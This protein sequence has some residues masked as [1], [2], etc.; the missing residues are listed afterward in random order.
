MSITEIISGS[1]TATFEA[2]VVEEY[3]STSSPTGTPVDILDGDVKLDGTAKIRGSLNITVNGDFPRRG[4]SLLA[5]YG[6]EIFIRRGVDIGSEIL[7]FPLGYFRITNVDQTG[8]SDSPIRIFGTDR[9]STILDSR[10]LQPRQFSAGTT[11]EDIFDNV[12]KEIYPDAVISFD[13]DSD[14]AVIGRNLV[15][16]EQRY[17][18]LNNIATALGKVM[19]FDGSGVLQIKSPPNSDTPVWEVNAGRHGVLINTSRRLSREGVYNAV[20]ARGEGGDDTVPVVGVAL[21]N[22]PNSPT[23]FGGRFGRIPRYFS[24]PF[25]TNNFQAKSAAD[26][27]LARATGMP[28]SVQFGAL[29]NPSLQP[30]EPIYLVHKNG[31]GEYHLIESLTIPLSVGVG[32]S[33]TTRDQTFLRSI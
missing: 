7:W 23:K 15:F 28:Y 2:V 5:P 19:Y 14:Q 9:M 1:H 10:L 20:V 29:V 33:A 27:L 30:F 32:M 4:T 13:D 25:I 22:N 17:D 11:V 6:N 18:T 24:S 16:E 26:H 8:S 3:Q 21:D 31:V 12:V